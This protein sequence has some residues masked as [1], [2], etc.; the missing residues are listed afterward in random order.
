MEREL[1]KRT[2]VVS[3]GTLEDGAEAYRLLFFRGIV[4]L[5]T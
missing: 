3:H 4:S 2:Y 1:T 5:L